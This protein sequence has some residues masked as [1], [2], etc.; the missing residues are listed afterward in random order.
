MRSIEKAEIDAS[1]RTKN[2]QRFDEMHFRSENAL[3]D[4]EIH[5]SI[6]KCIF[7]SGNGLFD[8]EMDLVF[9]CVMDPDGKVTG[10][11]LERYSFFY[12]KVQTKFVTG[13]NIGGFSYFLRDGARDG[14]DG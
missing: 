5:F 10:Q 7:R 4:P 6:R 14:S 11:N 8:P 9:F 2:P 12:V 3:F 1:K 13:Q